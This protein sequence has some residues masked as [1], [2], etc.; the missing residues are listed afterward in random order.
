MDTVTDLKRPP[1][2]VEG[3]TVYIEHGLL[4]I[5]GVAVRRDNVAKL[6]EWLAN[7]VLE[8]QIELPD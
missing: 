6:F 1:L 7:Y 5:N 2:R 8:A 3:L 4:H